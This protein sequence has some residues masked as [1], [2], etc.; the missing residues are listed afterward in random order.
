MKLEAFLAALAFRL[1]EV[2]VR[3]PRAA[4]EPREINCHCDCDCAFEHSWVLIVAL[5]GSLVVNCSQLCLRRPAIRQLDGSPA[6]QARGVTIM[7]S[8]RSSD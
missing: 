4:G 6:R 3:E 2:G 5:V 1:V 8:R 7:P